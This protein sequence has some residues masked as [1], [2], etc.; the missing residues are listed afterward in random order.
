M[1]DDQSI[2]TVTDLEK[3]PIGELTKYSTEKLY[4]LLGQVNESYKLSRKKKEWLEAA[5]SLKFGELFT[6][7]RRCQFRETGIVHIFDGNYRISSDIPKKVEWNQKLLSEI[8]QKLKSQG[9]D[10]KEYIDILY[11]ISETKYKS[12]SLGEKEVFMPA[13]TLK[14]GKAKYSLSIVNT[15]NSKGR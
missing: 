11:N 7:H 8:A 15:K 6:E 10:P 9:T 12:L 1:L 13:R 3:T 14:P 4:L 5:I 2:K